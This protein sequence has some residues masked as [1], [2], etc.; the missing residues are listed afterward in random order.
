ML[1]E[2]PAI[3]I[4]AHICC[5]YVSQTISCVSKEIKTFVSFVSAVITSSEN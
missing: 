3:A 2:H 4:R 1:V 5:K